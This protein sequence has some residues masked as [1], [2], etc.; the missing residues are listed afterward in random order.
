MCLLLG[1]P[2]RLATQR[3]AC[4]SDHNVCGEIFATSWL[5]NEPCQIFLIFHYRN[6]KY[7][8][9]SSVHVNGNWD[10]TVTSR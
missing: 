2:R 10:G 8:N 1:E 3:D 9:T 5:N 6:I 7:H 4:R